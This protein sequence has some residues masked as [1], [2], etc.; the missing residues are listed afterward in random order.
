MMVRRGWKHLQE[1]AM[2]SLR[3]YL[4]EDV[5]VLLAPL[6]AVHGIDCL[7]TVA[8][9]N[10]GRTDEEQ[11]TFATQ[12]SRVLVTHNRTDFEG[13]ALTWWAQQRDHAGILLAVRRSDTYDLLR[14]V[15]PVLQLYDQA[16]WRNMVLYA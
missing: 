16:G 2:S 8:D 12:E 3:V 11:L 1:M 15:L 7:T 9:G 14:R 13:L 6:L 10:V 5:D 4:D